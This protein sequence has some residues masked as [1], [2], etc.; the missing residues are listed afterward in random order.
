[1]FSN[2]T[3]ILSGY[4]SS[5]SGMGG[6]IPVLIVPA[7]LARGRRKWGELREANECSKHPTVKLVWWSENLLE[8]NFSDY[9]D[10]SR[11]NHS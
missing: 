8:Y 7:R 1:M 10:D 11:P 5:H 3:I 6:V 2:I 4:I 9:H